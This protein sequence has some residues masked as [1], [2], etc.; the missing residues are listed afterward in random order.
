MSSL[1]MMI[2][3]FHFTKYPEKTTYKIS[4]DQICFDPHKK[5]SGKYQIFDKAPI[6]N[7]NKW[8]IAGKKTCLNTLSH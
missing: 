8:D 3:R 4:A 2:C 1:Y 5:I 6:K 7:D